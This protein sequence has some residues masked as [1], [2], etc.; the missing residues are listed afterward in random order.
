[1]AKYTG[2]A[3]AVTVGGSDLTNLISCEVNESAATY[4]TTVVGESAETHLPG[5]TS[6]QCTINFLDDSGEASFD[7]LLPGGSYTIVVFPRGKTA[8]FQKRTFTATVTGRQRPVSHNAA[9]PVTV[10]MQV[11]G[12]ITEGVAP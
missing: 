8:G 12:A 4:D 5:K 7:A 1:M 6:A 10:T 11:N 9:V 2:N 3:L